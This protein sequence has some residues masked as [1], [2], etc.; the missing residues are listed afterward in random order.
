[1]DRLAGPFRASLCQR[2]LRQAEYHGRAAWR[3]LHWWPLK[4]LEGQSLLRNQDH[5]TQSLPSED[6]LS[7]GLQESNGNLVLRVPRRT[8]D[9]FLRMIQ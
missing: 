5:D 3:C 8:L 7:Y 9:R 1:M 4:G 6:Y 2:C